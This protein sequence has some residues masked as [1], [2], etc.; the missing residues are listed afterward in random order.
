M[1]SNTKRILTQLDEYKNKPDEWFD[2]LDKYNRENIKQEK[3]DNKLK[4]MM[5]EFD[6]IVG[7]SFIE[8]PP[9]FEICVSDKTCERVMEMEKF[10]EDLFTETPPPLIC[11]LDETFE[12]MMEMNKKRIKLIK[13]D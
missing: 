9:L 4:L 2:A 6:Q 5:R 13:L 11:V 1:T 12:R 10:D 7:D 3:A 8:I